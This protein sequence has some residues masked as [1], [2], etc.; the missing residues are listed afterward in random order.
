MGKTYKEIKEALPEIE[1]QKV[2]DISEEL[3]RILA[4]KTLFT[5]EGGKVLITLL[6]NNCSNTLRKLIL[7]SKDKP[8]LPTLLG[9]IAM[10]SANIDLLSTVQDIS[11][12][13]E[14][15]EQLDSAVK[16]AMRT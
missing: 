13:E 12:E 14:L 1:A 6:R 9:L 5:S 10:Y 7:V 3:D 15:R 2:R 16:E 8:D 11:I 4:I